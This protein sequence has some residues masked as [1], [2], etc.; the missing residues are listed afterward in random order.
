MNVHYKILILSYLKHGRL[1][2]SNMKIEAAQNYLL[3][4]EREKAGR[5]GREI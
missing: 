5:E 1:I 3:C 4:L 2:S